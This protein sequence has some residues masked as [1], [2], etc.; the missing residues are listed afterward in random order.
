MNKETPLK[1]RF[2]RVHVTLFVLLTMVVTAVACYILIRVY[3][4]PHIFQTRRTYCQRRTS[5]SEKTEPP[6]LH[7]HSAVTISPATL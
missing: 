4:F 1:R 3:L 7:P 6:R 5:P 2:D